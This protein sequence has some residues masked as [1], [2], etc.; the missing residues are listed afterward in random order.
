VKYAVAIG[1]T[2]VLSLQGLPA[3][4][5]PPATDAEALFK[6]AKDLRDKGDTW[7]ACVRFAQSYELQPGVG[8]ALYLGDCFERLDKTASAWTVFRVAQWL[9]TGRGDRRVAVA[10]RRADVLTHHVG[11]LAVAV[12]GPA[13]TA[14][15][16][17]DGRRLATSALD[18]P[19]PVDPG[20]HEVTLSIPHHTAIAKHARV[21]ADSQGATVRFQVPEPAPP[22]PPAEEPPRPPATERP[23][24]QTPVATPARAP[25]PSRGDSSGSRTWLAA[26]LLVGSAAA[27]GTGVALLNVKSASGAGGGQADDRA[28]ATSVVAFTAGAGAFAAA[29][30][31]LFTRPHPS[32]QA[33]ALVVAPM[34]LAGGGGAALS[35]SF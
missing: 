33:A 6:E 7:E 18:A 30:L 4:A 27:M 25:G 13:E 10:R 14:V 21:D 16:S 9:A 23:T 5:D 29:A 11:H 19:L 34:P 12:D 3:H 35:F 8:I 2:L 32:S 28:V 22:P 31:V 1:L 17:L 15:L 20:E 26:G 24:V